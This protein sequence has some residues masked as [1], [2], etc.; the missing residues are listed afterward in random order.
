MKV[1]VIGDEKRVQKYLPDLPIVERSEC[2]VVERGTSDA[3]IIARS[4]DA[5]AIVADAISP[6]SAQLMS[7]LGGAGR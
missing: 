6:V 5:D 7:A 3:D 4:G 2:T 1:V